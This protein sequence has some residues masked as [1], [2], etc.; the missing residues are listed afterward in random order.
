MLG[1]LGHRVAYWQHLIAENTDYRPPDTTAAT[2]IGDLLIGQR[3]DLEQL[4]VLKLQVLAGNRPL[5]R[6]TVETFM[7][8][9]SAI[10]ATAVAERNTAGQ[11]LSAHMVA[12]NASG[13]PVTQEGAELQAEARVE[14]ATRELSRELAAW[15]PLHLR[16][17]DVNPFHGSTNNA[18]YLM[19]S[20]GLLWL[21]IQ[22]PGILNGQALQGGLRQILPVAFGLKLAAAPMAALARGGFGAGSRGLAES[23]AA[24]S[25]Y[26]SRSPS[27]AFMSSVG[28]DITGQGGGRPLS[29]ASMLAR[30]EWNLAN[31]DRPWSALSGAERDSS[32]QAMANRLRTDKGG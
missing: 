19:F 20:M 31:P 15:L 23:R 6:A 18:I 29:P 10:V 30:D 2:G 13:A 8:Q 9:E 27:G 26:S 7:A 17:E 1:K 28:R 4:L 16:G 32:T 22:I 25:P 3:E 21:V 12:T 24:R 11:E 5:S 14:A